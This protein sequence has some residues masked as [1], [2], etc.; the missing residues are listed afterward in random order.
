MKRSETVKNDQRSGSTQPFEMNSGKRS[1]Y[2][3]RP[4]LVK[5][6]GF[7][8]H[9]MY[10]DSFIFEAWT[11]FL[12]PHTVWTFKT[13]FLRISKNFK[14]VTN[15]RKRSWVVDVNVHERL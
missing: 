13:I 2:V 9:Q 6:H 8:I 15:G 10:S 7:H 14:K 12:K 4:S 3:S 5:K 1:R 11:L